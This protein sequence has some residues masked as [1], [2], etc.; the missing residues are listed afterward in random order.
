M[1]AWVVEQFWKYQL[2]QVGHTEP[3]VRHALI[4]VSTT[5]EAMELFCAAAI[6]D[7]GLSFRPEDIERKNY[8]YHHYNVA[9]SNLA[10]VLTSSTDSEIVAL[11]TGSLFVINKFMWG[12]FATAVLHMHNEIEIFD[13]WSK[14]VG[15][16]IVEGSLEHNVSTLVQRQC[17][18]SDAIDD[19]YA[20]LSLQEDSFLEFADLTTAGLALLSLSKEGLRLIRV[21]WLLVSSY[22]DQQILADFQTELG[23]H[24]LL[25]S[26]WLAAFETLVAYKQGWATV[27]EDKE[28]DIF[29]LMYLSAHIWLYAGMASQSSVEAEPTELFANFLDRS[30]ALHRRWHCVCN[31]KVSQ[32]VTCDSGVIP[33]LIY[34]AAMC[35]DGNLRARA[36]A[37]ILDSLG[38]ASL[39]NTFQAP[40]SSSGKPSKSGGDRGVIEVEIEPGIDLIN[41]V[42]QPTR[43]GGWEVRNDYRV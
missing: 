11:M 18:K 7:P 1:S 38:S 5:H 4:A 2:P 19:L 6:Q 15:I 42:L 8:A 23:S 24:R 12:D 36:S 29:N 21:H 31:F 43:A 40:P 10:K 30:E 33:P 13:S 37:L 39:L 28:I 41:L 3:A 20:R 26:K 17:F 22:D 9:V 14:R 25:L 32:A 34:I 35:S 16:G 27:D